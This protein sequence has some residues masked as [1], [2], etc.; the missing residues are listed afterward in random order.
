MPSRNYARHGVKMRFG[1]IKKKCLLVLPVIAAVLCIPMVRGAGSFEDSRAVSSEVNVDSLRN[2]VRFL[3]VDMATSS[4]RSRFCLREEALSV[5][6]DSLSARLERYLEGPVNRLP[7]DFEM[8]LY[9]PDSSFSNDN[10]VIR[11]DGD[12]SIE[13]SFYITAHYD[14]IGVRDEGWFDDWRIHP[15]PGANDNASGVAALLETARALS[16]LNMPF[17]LVFV[18]FSAEELG[19]LGSRAYVA[20]LSALEVDD[21][22]GVFNIDMIGYAESSSQQSVTVVSNISSGWLADL[23]LRYFETHDPMLARNLLKPG[24]LN[25]DHASFWERSIDAISI[26][27]PLDENNKIIYPFYHSAA[28]TIGHIDFGQVERIASATA[29]LIVDLAEAP[30]EAALTPSDVLFYWWGGVTA[31]RTFETGDTLTVRIRPRN[32]GAGDAPEGAMINLEI[33][34]E[35]RHGTELLYS[36]SFPPP[37]PYR[38]VTIDLPIFLQDRHVGENMIRAEIEVSGMDDDP[39]DNEVRESFAVEGGPEIMLDHHFQPNPIRSRFDDAIF[40]VNLAA[41]TDLKIEIFN[42]EGKLLGRAFLGSR[43]GVPLEIGFNCFT[44]GDIL[45]G[46][47]S[48]ASGIYPYRVVLY[49]EGGSASSFTGRFAVEK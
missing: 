42:L 2:M 27:E 34:L 38:A 47:G 16:G 45:P 40:C 28:D 41:E 29:D 49:G 18:L 1:F 24:I 46:I 44:C 26:I 13:G 15:A 37:S 4:P 25:Y 35:N 31:S 12:G 7:F 6:A 9:A 36:D 30:A 8:E 11:L 33:N 21:I 32:L 3:S 17:D 20:D 22:L 14:A 19:L 39:S 48:L 43:S 23:V 5:I 10:I